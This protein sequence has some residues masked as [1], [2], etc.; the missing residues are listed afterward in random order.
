MKK[1]IGKDTGVEKW[2]R[3]WKSIKWVLQIFSDPAPS[4]YNAE[5]KMYNE[6]RD[7]F[8]LMAL[9]VGLHEMSKIL[10]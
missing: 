9:S 2:S 5:E 1:D 8:M 10:D 3:N 6:C 7:S 4:M